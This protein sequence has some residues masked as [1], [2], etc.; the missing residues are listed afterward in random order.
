MATVVQP[1][2]LATGRQPS[3]IDFEPIRE[4]LAALTE[5][6]QKRYQT[7]VLQEAYATY[8]GNPDDGTPADP[9]AFQ[10]HLMQEL[11]DPVA[12][13]KL[14]Q[15]LIELAARQR[16]QQSLAAMADFLRSEGRLPETLDISRFQ[17][18]EQ[19]IQAV[20]G[21]FDMDT[22]EAELDL[23]ERGLEVD[24]YNARTARMRALA[25]ASSANASTSGGLGN[26]Q[27][28][29]LIG[30]YMRYFGLD[31]NNPAQVA[32]ARVVVDRLP[33]MIDLIN[34]AAEDSLGRVSPEMLM[35]DDELG[36]RRA[37]AIDMAVAASM[38][39]NNPL[40]PDQAAAFG[41][42]Q[43]TQLSPEELQLHFMASPANNLQEEEEAPPVRDAPEGF[44]FEETL[45]Q[46]PTINA[47]LGELATLA[48]RGEAGDPMM[49]INSLSNIARAAGMP[50]S[51]FNNLVEEL[52]A[53]G[54]IPDPGR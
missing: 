1:F 42:Q 40:T 52:I 35:G 5:A 18:A 17:T 9:Y 7:K 3:P 26:T 4:G 32:Q 21:E 22:T 30:G 6:L 38:D 45:R 37:V 20:R 24:W 15:P 11:G 8:G 41:W 27:E 50:R 43:A 48:E 33:D 31:P 28:D 13:I 29:R 14:S 23:R 19:L 16:E 54:L 25:E 36:M 12:A 2:I 44:V 34:Q 49:N 51:E 39:P 46:Y 53:R 47:F 10:M